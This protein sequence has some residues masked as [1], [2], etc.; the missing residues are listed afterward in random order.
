MTGGGAVTGSGAALA[1]LVHAA[2]DPAGTVA[3]AAALT[4]V[5]P[6]PG[7]R[8]P[9][10]PVTAGPAA[11]R[12]AVLEGRHGRAAFGRGAVAP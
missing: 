1:P 4:G 2:P 5:R 12:T 3:E 8:W 7:V 9:G 11:R 10:E 6:A